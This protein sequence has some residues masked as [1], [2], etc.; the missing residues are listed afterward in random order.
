MKRNWIVAALLLLVAGGSAIVYF[1]MQPP[2]PPEQLVYGNGRIE[3]YEVRVVP[4]VPGRLA[5]N[6]VLEGQTVGQ[7]ELSARTDPVD[8]DLQARQAA[9]ERRASRFAASQLDAQ[10]NLAKH[11]MTTARSDL[12][13]DETLQRQGWTTVPQLNL[14]QVGRRRRDLDAG[15]VTIRIHGSSLRRISEATDPYLYLV[16]RG[17]SPSRSGRRQGRPD[18]PAVRSEGG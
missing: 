18:E 8:F 1:R 11:H 4:E 7:G 16:P 3:T 10:I 14:R 12:Q 17:Q 13:R 9:A 5:E 2:L 6:R 15:S